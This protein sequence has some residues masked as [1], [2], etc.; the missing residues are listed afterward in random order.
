MASLRS[1]QAALIAVAISLV[2]W[3]AEISVY[4]LLGRAFGIDMSLADAIV[5]MIAANLAGAIPI[6]PWNVGPYEVGCG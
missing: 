6:T 4:A 3:F 1:A 2:A 5:V